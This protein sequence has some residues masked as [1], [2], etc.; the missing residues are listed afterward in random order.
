MGKEIKN[1][2]KFK[3]KMDLKEKR[4]NDLKKKRKVRK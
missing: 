2:E 3:K 1:K 4:Y